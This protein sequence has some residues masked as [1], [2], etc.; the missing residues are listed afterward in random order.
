MP[1][2]TVAQ[3]R[4]Q[5]SP[6]SPCTS[7]STPSRIAARRHGSDGST[8]GAGAG[9]VARMKRS[10]AATTAAASSGEADGAINVSFG[11]RGDIAAF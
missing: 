2:R 1:W 4:S 10:S 5:G 3:T 6:G 7:R 8:A 9:A 11:A